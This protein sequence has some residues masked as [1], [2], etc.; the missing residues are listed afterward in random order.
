MFYF[1][2]IFVLLLVYANV[3]AWLWNV[4][5]EAHVLKACHQ[6]VEPTIER[7]LGHKGSNLIRFTHWRV[8]PS[9]AP[10]GGGDALRGGA[11]WEEVVSGVCSWGLDLVL[12]P[13]SS[14]LS[15]FWPPW[16]ELLWSLGPFQPCCFCFTESNGASQPR[17]ETSE[18]MSRSKSFL[19][20]TVSLKYL[21]QQRKTD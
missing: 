14:S 7:W 17:T 20:E 18:A 8:P 11:W 13:S 2:I 19:L 21:S 15:P 10:L 12:A 9:M 1:I 4:P 3:T 16:G 6:L 5:Q